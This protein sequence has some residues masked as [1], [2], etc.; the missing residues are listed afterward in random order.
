MRRE[1]ESSARAR[2]MQQRSCADL[3][4][5]HDKTMQGRPLQVWNGLQAD[6]ADPPAIFL[7]SNG[8]E[9]F[10]LRQTPDQTRFFGAPIGL[11]DFYD[12]RQTVTARPNHRSEEHTSEL[13]SPCN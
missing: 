10:I 7:D 5:G 3:P 1:V 12:P 6:T 4:E 11:I 8:N 13:Q 9:H 2:S